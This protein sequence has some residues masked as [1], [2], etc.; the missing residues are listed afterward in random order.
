MQRFIFGAV[1]MAVGI[2]WILNTMGMIDMSWLTALEWKKYFFP[3]LVTFIGFCI[4][5]GKAHPGS[6]HAGSDGLTEI[7][8]EELNNGNAVKASVAFAGN[9]YNFNNLPFYGGQFNIFCGGATLDLTHADVMDNACIEV[10][11]SLGGMDIL[12]PKDV[13]VTVAS[14]NLLGG[15]DNKCRNVE[16]AMKSITLKASCLLGGVEIKRVN[17]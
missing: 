6:R 1:V 10:N 11:A 13:N 7:N 5:V 4:I 9:K 3:A 15:V 12:L 14:Q 17:D 8:V 16:N 2:A